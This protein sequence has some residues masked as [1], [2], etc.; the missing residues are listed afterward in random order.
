ME[1]ITLTNVTKTYPTGVTAVSGL[2]LKISKGDF[3]FIT[4]CD[5]YQVYGEYSDEKHKKLK[6]ESDK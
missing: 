4:I 3:A 1:F 2:D 6:K 5:S